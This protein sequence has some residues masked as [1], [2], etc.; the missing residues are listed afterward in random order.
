MG[1]RNLNSFVDHICDLRE[2]YCL[3]NSLLVIDGN[4]LMHFLYVQY[5]D[6]NNDYLFGGNYSN[7]LPYFQTFFNNLKKCG[8]ESIIV[9]DGGLNYNLKDNR[10]GRF[11]QSFNKSKRISKSNDINDRNGLIFPFLLNEVFNSVMQEF[12]IKSFRTSFD[13]DLDSAKLSNALKCPLMSDDSDFLVLNIEF[14][15]ISCNG[16]QWKTPQL[17]NQTNSNKMKKEHKSY[18]IECKLYQI[19][20]FVNK[21]TGLKPEMLPIFASLMGNDFIN[22]EIFDDLFNEIPSYLLI[23]GWNCERNNERFF[24]INRVLIWLSQTFANAS[25]AINYINKYLLSKENNSIHS[26]K[27]FRISLNSYETGNNK[28]YLFS[29]FNKKINQS[30]NSDIFDEQILKELFKSSGHLPKWFLIEFHYNLKLSGVLMNFLKTKLLFL[31]PLIEDFSLESCFNCSYD[32]FGFIYGLLRS[33]EEDLT[34]LKLKSR[35]GNQI[36][37]IEILP[38]L[39]LIEGLEKLPVL[40]KLRDLS[41]IQSKSLFLKLLNFGEE[42]ISYSAESFNVKYLGINEDI[43]FWTYLVIV[44]KY[45]IQKTETSDWLTFVEAL[46]LN[47]IYH[48]YSKS[49]DE[50][51]FHAL[52]FVTENTFVP[53]IVH[54]YSEFQVCIFATDMLS[55]LLNHPLSRGQIHQYLNGVLIYKYNLFNA[56]NYRKGLSFRTRRL[57]SIYLIVMDVILNKYISK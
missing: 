34:P 11:E 16:F 3:S 26:I 40:T 29:L 46:V 4:N 48:K 49:Y 36:N 54:N 5:N 13:S 33:R 45:W 30:N 56:I 23:N 1:I 38:K 52:T 43:E 37:E 22:G 18:F 6:Q 55:S 31:K 12:N 19:N 17:F 51:D 57:Q 41:H 32:L 42:L 35:K 20:N 8:I 50:K 7:Y 2:T 10:F 24:L 9:F 44:I 14:G 27:M 28:T 25:H 15:V 47:I 21:F 39:Y 53:K